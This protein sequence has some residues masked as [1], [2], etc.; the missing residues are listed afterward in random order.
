MLYII[1]Y[2]DAPLERQPLHLLGLVVAHAP[3]DRLLALLLCVVGVDA[4]KTTNSI[5]TKVPWYSCMAGMA[6]SRLSKYDWSGCKSSRV[7]RSMPGCRSRSAA[8]AAAV[9]SLPPAVLAAAAIA[10]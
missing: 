2:E 3:H 7:C 9:D 4:P 1:Y 5:H 8:V 10:S 6:E